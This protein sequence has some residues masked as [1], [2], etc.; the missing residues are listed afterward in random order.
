MRV[1]FREH[2]LLFFF[3]QLPRLQACP[4]REHTCRRAD[5]NVNAV[6]AR[7]QY[8]R[9]IG[10]RAPALR[11]CEQV[12]FRL[13]FCRCI[14]GACLSTRLQLPLNVFREREIVDELRI[15]PEFLRRQCRKRGRCR[16]NVQRNHCRAEHSGQQTL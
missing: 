1:D 4:L 10:G 16:R 7:M 9:C 13:C 14:G 15:L 12:L 5:L 2:F 11:A 6:K 3:G 8:L